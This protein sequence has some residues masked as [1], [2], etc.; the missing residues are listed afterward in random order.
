MVLFHTGW[1]RE[2]VSSQT[3]SLKASVKNEVDGVRS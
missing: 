1:R 2:E 3:F